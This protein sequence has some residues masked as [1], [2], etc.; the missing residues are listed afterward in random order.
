MH[1]E[2]LYNIMVLKK[3][4]IIAIF[5]SP[6]SLPLSG[7]ARVGVEFPKNST[8]LLKYPLD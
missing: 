4:G 8:F 2:Y 7:A 1:R 6:T 5:N 3:R